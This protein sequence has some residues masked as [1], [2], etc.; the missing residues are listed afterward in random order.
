MQKL[1]AHRLVV[2]SHARILTHDLERNR[3][4]RA[5]VVGEE[6]LSHPT[7]AEA[8]TD[9]VPVIDDRAWTNGRGRTRHRKRP[10]PPATRATRWIGGTSESSISLLF[11]M[12]VDLRGDDDKA[13]CRGARAGASRPKGR[14]SRARRDRRARRRTNC[15]AGECEKG[16]P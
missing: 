3:L 1:L 2:A 10:T 5:P 11:A 7:F 13:P 15:K 9:L 14:S 4:L 6:H 8:L 16:F 12:P